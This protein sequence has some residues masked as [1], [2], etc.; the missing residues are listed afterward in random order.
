MS[1]ADEQAGGDPWLEAG[2][3]FR[4]AEMAASTPD[5][6][7]HD[8]TARG[9]AETSRAHAI[10]DLAAATVEIAGADAPSSLG[11][12][13]VGM[14]AGE[15]GREAVGGGADDWSATVDDLLRA[16]LRATSSGLAAAN[17]ALRTVTRHAG[18]CGTGFVVFDLR[19][20][21]MSEGASKPSCAA[22]APAFR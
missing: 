2:T 14:A 17:G 3:V 20:P 5:R 18:R 19:R 9:S 6:S 22:M 11:R 7:L 16:T 8:P 13:L 12:A 1:C 10:I 15:A 4:L 21:V